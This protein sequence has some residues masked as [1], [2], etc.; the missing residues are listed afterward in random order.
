M[1]VKKTTVVHLD[2]ESPEAKAMIA[3]LDRR[4]AERKALLAKFG[5]TSTEG[6]SIDADGKP[7]SI[8]EDD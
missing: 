4:I 2:P 7:C 3:D 5:Y 8:G 1:N 6:F